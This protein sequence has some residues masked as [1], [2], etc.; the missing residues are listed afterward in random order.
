M[1]MRIVIIGVR[2]HHRYVFDELAKL[3]EV[4]IVGVSSGCGDDI[5]PLVAKCRAAG[6]APAVCAD[7]RQMLDDLKPQ[8][9]VINGPFDQHARMSMEALQRGMHVFC[10]KPVAL[11]LEDLD[12]LEAVYGKT[13]G[14]FIMPMV[15][16]RYE[17]CFMTAWK[18]VRAGAIGRVKMIQAR[19]SY[20][21]GTRP[22]FFQHRESYGGTIPW[23]GSH[24]LDWIYWFSGADF[25]SVTA[26][27]TT[28]DNFGHGDL[29]IAAQCQLVMKNGVQASASIDYLRPQAAET[30]GD[31]RVRV[32][33]TEG[34][35]EVAGGKTLLLDARGERELA[36]EACHGV[37]YDFVRHVQGV[38][39]SFVTSRDTFVLTRACLLARQSADTGQSVNF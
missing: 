11:T 19:K 30:H 16:L 36:P 23:V 15:G 38:S 7:Y 21:L 10:E 35:I 14:L 2:G 13:S 39:R 18:A 1:A 27:Q 17:P 32:A 28:E 33:G 6:I 22:E 29:E 9:V 4:E 20:K 34:V 12:R 24:A 37:F 8:A 3:P 26:T 25:A 5:D 31:D